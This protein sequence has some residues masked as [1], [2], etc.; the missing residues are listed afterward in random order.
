MLAILG[1]NV[2]EIAI[3][4][5]HPPVLVHI[6]DQIGIG[7]AAFQLLIQFFNFG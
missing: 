3:L 2:R 1:D 5:M 7:H 6:A 4:L